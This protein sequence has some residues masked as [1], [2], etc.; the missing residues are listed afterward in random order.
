VGDS[1]IT[2]FFDI[3]FLIRPPFYSRFGFSSKNKKILIK[4]KK[5]QMACTYQNNFFRSATKTKD[6]LF[7]PKKPGFLDIK[8]DFSHQKALFLIRK[9]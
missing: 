4:I 6:G 2:K 3:S 8:L 7:E 5:A 9:S 1:T